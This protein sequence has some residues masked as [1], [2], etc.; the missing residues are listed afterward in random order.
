MNIV[1]FVTGPLSVN[2]WLVPLDER[3]MVVV[4]PGG[5][6]DMI[7]TYLRERDAFPV[8]FALTHGHFDHITALPELS[9]A[10]P[11]VPIA[12]HEADAHFLG[13]GA[14]ERHRSFFTRIGGAGLVEQY[15][16]PLPAATVFFAGGTDIAS[17]LSS[18]PKSG[19]VPKSTDWLIMHTPGH[20]KGSVCLYNEK[21]KV[22]ISGDTLFNSGVGRTDAPGGNIS[23]LDRSLDALSALPGETIVLPGHGPRT[24]IGQELG[25]FRG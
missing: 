11:D 5:D 4:D 18:V 1:H 10:F 14:L 19:S 8:L 7:I 20:S 2:T 17:V 21:E 23:E 25:R 13:D 9:A 22:L 6:A 15:S 3:R 12:I 24:T 16:T